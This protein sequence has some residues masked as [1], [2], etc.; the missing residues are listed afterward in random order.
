MN[1]SKETRN[2]YFCPTPRNM[3]LHEPTLYFPGEVK[4]TYHRHISLNGS[5]IVMLSFNG[6]FSLKTTLT[7]V[8]NI[9]ENMQESQS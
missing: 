7:Y 1:F 3:G 6:I 4:A 8:F 2:S 5:I 9:S